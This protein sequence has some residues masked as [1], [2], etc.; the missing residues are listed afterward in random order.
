MFHL[1]ADPLR[2]NLVALTFVQTSDRDKGREDISVALH[3]KVSYQA[4]QL[5]VNC[6]LAVSMWVSN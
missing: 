3:L 4:N 6:T 5:H 2:R 1:A